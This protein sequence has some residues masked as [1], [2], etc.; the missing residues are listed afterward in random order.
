MAPTNFGAVS[1]LPMTVL[2]LYSSKKF[3]SI[4]EVSY[5]KIPYH[6]VGNALYCFNGMQDKEY[7]E[8]GIDCGGPCTRNCGM[9]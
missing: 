9:Q 8:E 7:G 5:L 3:V 2:F 4:S 6:F 1:N